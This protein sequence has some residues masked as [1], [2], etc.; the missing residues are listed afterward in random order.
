VLAGH[1]YGGP[2]IA[3]LAVDHP[4]K[5]GGVVMVAA[6]LDPALEKIKIIQYVAR[7]PLVRLVVPRML[8]HCN[9][10]LIPLKSELLQLQPLLKQLSVPVA[11]VHGTCD[12]LVPFANV[13]FMHK[14]FPENTI[15]HQAILQGVGHFLP[16]NNYEE[17]LS[18]VEVFYQ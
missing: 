2:V 12:K 14:T 10:E 1:S 16:W 6:A 9:E 17:I 13:D 5:V 15:I 3:R 8:A 7:W 18:A 4:D 11:I